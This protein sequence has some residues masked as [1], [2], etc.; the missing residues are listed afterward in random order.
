VSALQAGPAAAPWF[1]VNP[2]AGRVRAS[3]LRRAIRDRFADREAVI[4]CET[5]DP[6][7]PRLVVAV[8]GDG[9]VNRVINRCDPSRLRLG[10][11][12]R[13][14]ANDLGAELRIP[15]DLGGAFD[16]IEAGRYAEIDLVSVN[17]SRFATCGGFGLAADVAMRANGWKA[18]PRG[19]VARRL[20]PLVYLLAA[21]RE[22]VGR[23]RP[24]LATIRANGATRRVSLTTALV[25]NQAR[26]GGFFSA[27]PDASNRDG[28]LHL[29]AVAAPLG[30]ARLMWVAARLLAGRPVSSPKL[31]DLRA[32]SL[33]VETD[34]EVSFFGDGEVLARGRRFQLDVLPRALRV[35]A[36]CPRG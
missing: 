23:P 6:A 9:T 3:A 30:R 20:G 31:L 24:I 25:S 16:V 26:F 33:T 32:R 13:G 21:M 1:V 34:V 11:V 17:G 22:L 29:C 14:S 8:G 36:S 35:A 15:R 12:P 10:I 18:G 7:A 28:E 4:S 27:S 19:R 2:H 5:P